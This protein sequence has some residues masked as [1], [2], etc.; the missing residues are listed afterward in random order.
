M[1]MVLGFGQQIEKVGSIYYLVFYSF[2]TAFPLLYLIFNL[3]FFS[4][5][6]YLNIVASFE[7]IILFS[8][9]FLIKFP[10]YFLHF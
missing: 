9:G 8:L 3:P 2:L 1:L 5:L 10:V 7:F 4:T 6:V